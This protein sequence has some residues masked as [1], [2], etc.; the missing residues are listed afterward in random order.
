MLTE[1]D[2]IACVCG[3]LTRFGWTIEKTSRETQKGDDI[4]AR[5]PNNEKVSIEA[6]GETSSQGYVIQLLPDQTDLSRMPTKGRN[7][8]IIASVNNTLHFR[9]FDEKGRLVVDRNEEELQ[10]EVK[11]ISVLKKGLENLWTVSLSDAQSEWV[12]G[13]V[14]GIIAHRLVKPKTPRYGKPFHLRQVTSDVAGAYYRASKLSGKRTRAGVAFPDNK[15]HRRKVDAIR[16]ALEQ[17]RI[18]VFWAS[19]ETKKVSVV[20][21]GQWFSERKRSDEFDPWD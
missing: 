16:S 7:L 15:M 4:I 13:Q 18:T 10:S 3:Y 19:S 8:T 12:L 21:Y 9:Y 6:K 2:V 11:S 1:S 14:G 20:D 5:A 17:L